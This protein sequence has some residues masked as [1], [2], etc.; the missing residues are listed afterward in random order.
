ML[1]RLIRIHCSWFGYRMA[2]GHI[3][4][5]SR[6]SRLFS[7]FL[8]R[9]LGTGGFRSISNS[10]NCHAGPRWWR[11]V[12]YSLCLPFSINIK[13]LG[14]LIY[15]LVILTI[16]CL[17]YRV[18]LWSRQDIAIAIKHANSVMLTFECCFRKFDQL[19]HEPCLILSFLSCVVEPLVDCLRAK[20]NLF[21]RL[22]DPLEVQLFV[23]V[24]LVQLL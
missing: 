1:G 19:V 12:D 21:G 9:H 16:S 5:R 3:R 4:Q 17:K 18:A 6:A 22:R 2:W 7:Q 23:F 8:A 13:L 24:R 14:E 15:K 10:C 20:T 11:V